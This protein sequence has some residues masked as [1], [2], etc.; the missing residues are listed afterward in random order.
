MYEVYSRAL[1]LGI[2]GHVEGYLHPCPRSQYT[3]PYIRLF[4]QVLYPLIAF[5]KY[6]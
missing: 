4:S 5:E 3:Q 1:C 6:Y 2:H